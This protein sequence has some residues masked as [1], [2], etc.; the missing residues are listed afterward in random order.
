MAADKPTEKELDENSYEYDIAFSFLSQDEALAKEINDLLQDRLK[1]F[2]YSKK[3][4]QLAGTDG[5]VIFNRIFGEESRIAVVLYRSGWG[6]TPWTRIE[7]TAIRNRAHE[8]GYDFA[9][10]IPLD[11]PPIVPKWL[12]KTR[13]WVGFKRWGPSG[14]ASVIEARVQEQ[15]GKLH[16]ETVQERAAR[17]ER[18]L[19]FNERRDQFLN[20]IEGVS[21]ANQEFDFLDKEL[22]RLVTEIK[23]TINLNIKRDI[24]PASA[25]KQIVILGLKIGLRLIWKC[26]FINTLDKS[27]LVFELW[28][29]H[30]PFP[31]II[32]F[33][34]KK[35][36]ELKFKLD[37][38]PSEKYIWH[39]S[40]NNNQ[41]DTKQ[42]ASFILKQFLNEVQKQNIR[43]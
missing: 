14:A 7:E 27:V 41:Y 43:N 29:D 6:K 5:E 3:Q 24:K 26:P 17:L 12:P 23:N 11:E 30:P 37:F 15:G 33:N 4:E 22:Q 28:D 13:L 2:L 18:A 19:K 32:N 16:E 42:L 38:T 21:A 40:S 1:S 10:F 25:E 20:S 34:A 9:I 35:M 8:H 36:K 39:I 31:G